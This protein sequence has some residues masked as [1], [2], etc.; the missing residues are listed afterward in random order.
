MFGIIVL[1]IIRCVQHNGYVNEVIGRAGKFGILGY[2]DAK[3]NRRSRIAILYDFA[4]A[5]TKEAL[6]HE[7][8]KERRIKRRCKL[9]H[10]SQQG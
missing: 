6:V 5:K 9:V 2:S 8:K 4:E 10:C 3:C 7:L 1:R